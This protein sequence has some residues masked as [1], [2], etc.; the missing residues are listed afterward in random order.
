MVRPSKNQGATGGQEQREQNRALI[1]L[2]KPDL[3]RSQLRQKQPGSP[4]FA[5][6]LSSRRAPA[7]RTAYGLGPR[8]IPYPV[9]R[10]SFLNYAAPLTAGLVLIRG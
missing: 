5:S 8:Q 4:F 7:G 9:L 2:E 1:V 10:S 6:P 3:G